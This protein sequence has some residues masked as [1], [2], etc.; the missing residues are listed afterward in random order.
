MKVGIVFLIHSIG[1]FIGMFLALLLV[2]FLTSCQPEQLHL[3]NRIDVCVEQCSEKC[4][5]L[6]PAK[7]DPDR[8]GMVAACTN[9]CTAR[10][11]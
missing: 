10:C 8:E 6:F 7:E 4:E 2:I 1:C 9:S 5:R 3:D 11:M